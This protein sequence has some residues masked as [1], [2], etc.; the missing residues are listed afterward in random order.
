MN[1]LSLLAGLLIVCLLGLLAYLFG[2]RRAAPAMQGGPLTPVRPSSAPN[3]IRVGLY[4]IHR[5]R[6]TDG[7][8]DL[9]RI[10]DVIKHVDVIGLCE[11]Q[12]ASLPG[13]SDQC[14]QLGRKLDM[15][16]L[17]SPTQKRW[18]RYDRGNGLLSCI[19]VAH[20]QQEP[21]SDSTGTHPR[22]LLRADLTI[23]GDEIPLFVTHLA[24]RTDQAQQLEVV[25]NRV[26]H[27]ERAILVGDLNLM[28]ESA[29]LAEAIE[30]AGFSDAIALT[31]ERD[32]PERID[33][34]FVRGIELVD[35]GCHPTGPSDHPFYWVEL[36][37]GH[38]SGNQ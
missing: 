22:C 30:R 26:Q 7:R 31:M 32:D 29:L 27:Y 8:K 18:G 35:G 4:N 17:F 5:A 23:A 10:A 28:R 3:R 33:W 37:V 25:I 1:S 11:V 38:T 2:R 19:P 6:G 13:G 24:R 36:D 9:Q 21:L 20:W 14:Q 34:I 15:A 16:A 12:G